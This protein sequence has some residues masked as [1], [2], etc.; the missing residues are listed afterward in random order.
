MKS[1]PLV[2]VLA[3]GMSGCPSGDPCADDVAGW[4]EV[5]D[6][7]DAF[8]SIEDG[9]VLA[10]EYGSQGGQHVWASIRGD[11]MHPGSRDVSEGL[12]KDNLPWISFELDGP[13][14][15][16]S[17]DNELRQ[18]LQEVEGGW[19]FLERRI[20]FRFWSTLPDDWDEI[21]REVRIA[22]LEGMDFVL[23]GRVE[24]ACGDVLEDERI[25]RLDFPDS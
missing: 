25:V 14:G 9:A 17:N 2:L 1:L 15:M 23:R 12:R 4:I 19:G 20:S 7:F 24:D 18:P 8:E 16:Y 5:G 11:G 13:D 21:P 3:A 22:E 10:V 6:G